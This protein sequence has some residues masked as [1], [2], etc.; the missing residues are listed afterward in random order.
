MSAIKRNLS[1]PFA[2]LALA[3]TAL[4]FTAY[5]GGDCCAPQKTSDKAKVAACCKDKAACCQ[6][7]KACCKKDAMQMSCCAGK[8]SC[9][10]DKKKAHAKPMACC[11]M[12]HKAG[13]IPAPAHQH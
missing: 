8:A 3:I 9:C 5:A 11:A 1:L 12:K 13:A 2:T 10:A 7:D 4:P 6:K